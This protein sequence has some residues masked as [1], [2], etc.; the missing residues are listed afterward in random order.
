MS[1]INTS[2]GRTSLIS[3]S[4]QLLF[5]LRKTQN[6]LFRKQTEI[7]T[8]K[9]VLKPSDDASNASSLLLLNKRLQARGQEEA[10]LNNSL[11]VLN[12]VDSAIGEAFNIALEARDI[13]SSQIGVGSDQQTRA[14]Q[15]SVIDEQLRAMVEI[16]NRQV[17][18]L[19]IFG[20][21]NGAAAGETVFEEFLGGIRYVGSEDDLATDI[22]FVSPLDF[23]SNGISA[24]GSLSSR[25]Q[26]EVDLDPDATA[27]TRVVDVDGAVNR[28]VTLGAVQLSVNGTAANVDLTGAETLGDVVT[29]IN[30][31]IDTIDN[32]AGSVAISGD[33]FELTATAGNTLTITDIGT[34]ITAEDLGIEL[35]AT[36]ATVAG[37]DVNTRL[38]KLTN[39]SDLGIGIDFAS[40]LKIT[41]G[42]QT[43]VADFS[44][45]TTV[46]D[47]INVID[48]LKLGLRME[49]NDDGTGVNLISEVSG[50][51]LAIGENSGGTTATDLGLR[52][53]DHSTKLG[54]FRDGLG[55]NPQADKDD[56]RV[57]LHDGTAFDVNLDG[58]STV[59]DVIDAITSAA[60]TAGLTVGAVGDGASD[61]NIGFVT[62]GNGF[63]FEDNTA[64]G[65][66]FSITKLNESL[67]AD[68]LGI[69]ANA[70][71]AASI[72]SADNATVKVQSVF[73][74]LMRLRDSL[75]ENN[76]LGITV[77][78]SN[79]EE[80]LDRLTRARADVGVRA[81]RVELQI[82][83]SE[84]L[85]VMEQAMRSQLQ[86]AD[87]TEVITRFQQLQVQLQA[88]LQ[89]ASAR[90]Q[91][92]FLDF[93]G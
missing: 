87:L 32:T 22:G 6:E 65:T 13:A 7:S 12:N 28:G 90:S 93:L 81:Q 45:A 60:T 69:T 4:D 57:T 23:T 9:S 50:I 79:L 58:S 14:N 16:A 3:D 31:A 42:Q 8:G 86:D 25:V 5:Q 49:V 66:D 61:F 38:T 41:Q 71:A 84:E 21:N 78:G 2:F 59:Q 37:A 89:A 73:T 56:L 27:N 82:E 80:S 52:S 75:S 40:G 92:S 29:R 70:G 55:V 88:S 53:L 24:F 48:Q 62:D 11:G 43:K 36:G 91:L 10:N 68:H 85:G 15:A 1:S 18:G 20:G 47:M 34:G 74:D 44:S 33:G 26:G 64:G 46:E 72:D 54:A 17:L 35:S 83:R 67:A 76:E 51:E 19:S 39:L 30:N 77:A 63:R